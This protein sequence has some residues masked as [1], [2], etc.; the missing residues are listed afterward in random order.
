M[1][2][3]VDP[4]KV[5]ARSHSQPSE[6]ASR[7][8]IRSKLIFSNALQVPQFHK[9]GLVFGC[10]D[11]VAGSNHVNGSECEKNAIVVTEYVHG[12]CETFVEPCGSNQSVYLTV[13]EEYL[14]HP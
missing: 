10:L 14:N 13:Q 6:G 1:K 3:L 12:N 8:N 7:N 2:E 11:F 5:E 9:Y 4:S